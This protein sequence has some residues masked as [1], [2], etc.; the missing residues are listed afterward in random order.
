MRD[1]AS[2]SQTAARWANKTHAMCSE[3]KGVGAE[4]ADVLVKRWFADEDTTEADLTRYTKDLADGFKK[5][6]TAATSAKLIFTDNPND[7]GGEFEESEAY[8]WGDRLNVVYIEGDFFG[9]DN[10]LTGAVNWVRIVVHE[11]SHLKVNTADVPGRYA[12]GGIQPHKGGFPASKASPT[13][14]AGRGFQRIA[15][16][17]SAPRTA[18]TR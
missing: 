14:T 11:L 15:M 6:A 8:V 9:N 10:L 18:A 13:L 1:L 17:P 5:I 12:W 16:A 2:S 4:K 7:R 3:T